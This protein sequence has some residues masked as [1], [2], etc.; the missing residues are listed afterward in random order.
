MADES[1]ELAMNT[2]GEAA[3]LA[4]PASVRNLERTTIW[5]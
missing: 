4:A 1:G 3:R 2:G 5:G